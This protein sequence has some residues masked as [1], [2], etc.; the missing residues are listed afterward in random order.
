MIAIHPIATRKP[1]NVSYDVLKEYIKDNWEK[2]VKGDKEG[3]F[4]ISVPK[5]WVRGEIHTLSPG[6]VLVSSVTFT[7][8]KGVEE[9]PRMEMKVEDA[10]PDPVN[11][12][13]VIV[14]SRELLGKDS[15]S[16]EE[17]EVI[18]IRGLLDKPNPRPLNTLLHNIFNQSGGTPV[19]GT[20]EEKLK[21]I[22]ESFLFWK[23]K[24]MVK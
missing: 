24:V 14:Y 2:K 13:D 4:H 9:D 17:Y 15:S 21:M 18:A 12:A 10:L 16:E 6:E 3:I 7:S 22:E 5:E 23:D 1:I 11:S 20:A 8:R 19:E